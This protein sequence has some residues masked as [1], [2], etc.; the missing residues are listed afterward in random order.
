MN[1][2]TPLVEISDFSRSAEDLSGFLQRPDNADIA[3][4]FPA[5]V[6]RY[7]VA[8]S[9][10]AVNLEAARELYEVGSREQFIVFTGARAVGMC[11]ITN[12]ID[13][14]EGIDPGVPNISGFIV[15]PFRGQGLGRFSIEER[16]KVIEKSFNNRAWT[17][18]KDGNLPSEHLVMS[19]GFR[20]T[21]RAIEGWEGHHLYLFGDT[22]S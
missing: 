7:G 10:V 3:E 22:N 8:P 4:E 18:V 2:L 19:V 12:Q 13:I 14:P 11:L 9:E 6:S 17:F 1:K 16:I 15:N 21:N 5:T 20:K